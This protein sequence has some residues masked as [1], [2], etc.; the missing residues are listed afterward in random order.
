MVTVQLVDFFLCRCSGLREKGAISQSSHRYVQLFRRFLG[1][2][3]AF[4]GK[5][6]T[7]LNGYG[8]VNWAEVFK[9][10]ENGRGTKWHIVEQESYAYAPLECVK[11]C[12]VRD[13]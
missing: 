1:V 13:D 6:G 3:I 9:L 4:S 8:Q 2:F 12:R 10:S 11:R 5:T 7:Q